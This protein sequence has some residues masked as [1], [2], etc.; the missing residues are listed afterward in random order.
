MAFHQVGGRPS[1]RK[2]KGSAFTLIELLVVI[3]IIALLVSILLP[4]L[5]QARAVAQAAMCASNLHGVYLAGTMYSTDW[6]GWLAPPVIDYEYKG[7]TGD[8]AFTKD[9]KVPKPLVDKGLNHALSSVA[10]H[11]VGLDYMPF[12]LSAPGRAVS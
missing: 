5:S 3:A 6:D 4:S 9:L 7:G 8:W 12:T 2:G 10:T 11:Y 1:V